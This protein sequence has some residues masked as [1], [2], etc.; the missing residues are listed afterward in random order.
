MEEFIMVIV[1]KN[2]HLMNLMKGILN[3]FPQGTT[4]KES[5]E[6]KEVV[7]K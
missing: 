6:I 3:D 4:L 7:L 5:E 2:K 1:C